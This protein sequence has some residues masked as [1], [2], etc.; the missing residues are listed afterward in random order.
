M[1]FI[2][3]YFTWF[4]GIKPQLSYTQ[5]CNAENQA[6]PLACCATV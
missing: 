5:Y 1:S 3:V 6:D 2:I 4:M